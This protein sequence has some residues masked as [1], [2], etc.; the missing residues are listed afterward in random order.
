MKSLSMAC[1]G[2]LTALASAP[3]SGGEHPGP[4]ERPLGTAASDFT[5][6]LAE[7]AFDP[8]A[9]EPDVPPGWEGSESAG[10][11]LHLIQFGGP[12]A[13]G[14]LAALR[15]GGLEPVQYIHPN[16][17]IV[18]GR[19]ERRAALSLDGSIRWTGDF[20]PAF[21]VQPQWRDLPSDAVDVQVL[22][23][24]GAGADGV[25]E[26]ISAIGGTLTG[27]RVVGERLEVAGYSLPGDRM[28][29]AAAI[30]GVYSI[31]LQSSDGGSRSEVDAQISAGNVDGSNVA[32]PGYAPWLGTLG[33]SGS[34]V[35]VASVDEGI[36]NH[37]DLVGRLLP[38]AGDS[39]VNRRSWHGTHTAGIIAGDATSGVLDANGFLRGLG[40]APGANLI[41]Q[42]WRPTFEEPGGM[43]KLMTE[44]YA[45]GASLSNNSW[46]PSTT[47]KGYDIDTLLVDAGVRDADPDAL[48]NQPLIYVQ[49]IDNGNGG[50]STQGTPDDAKNILTVG[51][52]PVLTP[53]DGNQDPNI[54][55]LSWNTAHGPARDGRTIP[56]LVAPG[57]YTDSTWWETVENGFS[58][59]AVCGT[60]QAAAHVSGAVALFVEYY[61]GLPGTTGNP[62]PALV[63]AALLAVAHDLQ[64]HLD[65][66]GG[67]MGHRPDSKQGWGRLDLAAV[68]DPSEPVLYFDQTEIFDFTGQQWSRVVSAA[69]PAQPM[70]V[71]LVW[72]DA[73]G[74]GLGGATP[75]WNNDLDLIVVAG[76]QTYLGNRFGSNGFS[77]TGGTR[78]AMNNAEGVFLQSVSGN[79]T[80]RVAAANINSNGV[81]HHGDDSDQDFA[82]A[83]YNCVLVPDF[84]LSSDPSTLSVCAPSSG[85]VTV[86]VDRLAGFG[87][88]VTL[89]TTGVPAGAGATFSSNPVT[90][91]ATSVM[92]LNPGTAAT[93]DYTV[94]VRGDSSTLNR[95]VDVAVRIRTAPPAPAALTSPANAATGVAPRPVLAWNATAWTDLYLVEVATDAVFHHMVYS[96]VEDDTT[97]TLGRLLDPQALYYWRVR[98]TNTCGYGA[99]ST[100]RSFT[101][102]N[103]PD[104]LLVDDDYD[105]PNVR[106]DYA[107][108]LS[109]LG[110]S[111]DLWD[112]WAGHAGAEPDADTLAIHDQVIWFSGQEEIYPG[113]T[114]DSEVALAGWLD[115]TGCLLLSS[116]D[117][118]LQQGGAASLGEFVRQRLGVA[119]V[120]EDTGMNQV[121]GQ[122]S[123]YGSDASGPLGPF[124]LSNLNPDYRDA[125][126]PDATA[127]LAFSGNLGNAGVTK[128]GGW[129]RTSFLGFGLETTSSTPRQRILGAFLSWCA[130]LPAVDGDMDGVSNGADCAP[131]DPAV[132]TA[133]SPITNLLLGK[134]A[135]GFSWSEPAGGSGARYDVLRAKNAADFYDATCVHAG[136][137]A[138]SAPPDP[139]V[140]PPGGVLF[141]LVGATTD[142]GLSTLGNN[143]D[144]SPRYGTACDSETIWWD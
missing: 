17:Y 36:D 61:R 133:P 102:A 49:A 138:T 127:E 90:P 110:V 34:G 72:T 48:G 89:S 37:P 83:C 123:V 45:N 9:G 122:G 100:V 107:A 117:Y 59:Q 121:T 26:R 58:Y 30:P 125:V 84:A 19:R 109:A 136:G 88:P 112:V 79:A 8:V 54:D 75:A 33:L 11:D 31:Q 55:N 140:P 42:V 76:G 108:A 67:V 38:C 116:A 144:G 16:T 101:I 1:V 131:D 128:N 141:Y 106:G 70:R 105:V 24:R 119:S 96:A 28:R 120:A 97:H 50:V 5:L 47:A 86:D 98:A 21:R 6:R 80:L 124:S 22:I 2:L 91:P 137:S 126:T 135:V 77:A 44:S 115:G 95:S 20:A 3:T 4:S 27:R 66:D 68:V 132:S 12:I 35:V 114:D 104:L 43:L 25:V 7:F 57:C 142:C 73:P 15:D 85:T 143:T 130:G 39:C 40:M 94:Q 46:G 62:S 32:F 10:P 53:P 52:T 51:S 87:N 41:E 78:D 74:H 64:G 29:D 134:G 118:V 60:S 65:A 81:P 103:V 139:L 13:H 92:T 93:G 23:Y 111:Y 63:K 71:M 69:N 82:V 113:P 56:H 18:W 129:Y 14:A 99:F